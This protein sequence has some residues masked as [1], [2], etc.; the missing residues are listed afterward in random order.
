[1][2]PLDNYYGRLLTSKQVPDHLKGSAKTFKALIKTG[3]ILKCFRCQS[4]IRQEN[5]LATGEYYCRKCLV[6]GRLTSND[7]LFHFESKVFPKLNSLLWQGQLTSFQEKISEKLIENY[8]KKKTTLVHAVT[9]AGKTEMI[10]QL[11]ATVLDQGGWVC[12]ASPRIDVCVELEKRMAKDFSCPI[13]LMYGQAEAYQ[14]RPLIIATIHQLMKFYQAFDLLVVDEVDSF[15]YVDNAFLN[16]A[17]KNALKKDGRLVL[18][19]A[20]S[21]EKLEKK[22]TEGSIE[23]ISLARRFHNQPL[24]VP[25]FKLILSL[26]E[27]INQ[28]RLPKT[29][30]HL[31]S[32]QRQSSYPL[33]IFFP[34]IEQGKQFYELIIKNFPKESVAFV[35]SQAIKRNESIEQFRNKEKTILITTTILERGV[36]FPCIDVF[37]ILSNHRLYNSSSLVQISGRVGRSSDRP[38]G[39]LLFIH[40][41]IS[42]A[43]IKA[44]KEIQEMNK[45]AYHCE[46]SNL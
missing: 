13:Q 17:R 10:Y 15:P 42:R 9:G 11:V 34:T 7:Y 1:M 8:K 36:T 21:T 19:T 12:I 28:G 44:R 4:Q 18:L 40:D 3:T 24:V 26:S 16:Q 45:E 32:K 35:S 22:V 43:M 23:K 37:V 46:L 39:Q 41:G 38:S 6:F 33:L 5:Q 30:Y 27:Q 31:I 14:R 2:D 25:D 29:L 20:T